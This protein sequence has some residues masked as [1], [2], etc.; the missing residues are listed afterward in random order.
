MTTPRTIDDYGGVKQDAYPIEDPEIEMSSAEDMR[1][2]EDLAELT[3]TSDHVVL[4]FPTST[5]A[6]GPVVPSSGQSH[7]GTGSAALPTV[8]KVGTG[9]YN[10]TYPLQFTDALGGTPEAI[11][12]SYSGGRVKS[13]SVAGHVQTTEAGR[14]L[15][16]AVFDLAGVASDLTNGTIVE[17]DGR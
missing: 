8:A 17:I 13:L 16:V 14:I 7:M 9:L 10:V 1:R 3:R 15:H 6:N 2:S 4:K 12:F 11:S 5:G